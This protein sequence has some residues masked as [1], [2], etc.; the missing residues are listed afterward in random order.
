MKEE[1]GR[2]EEVKRGITRDNDRKEEKR[3]LSRWNKRVRERA[4]RMK[5]REIKNVGSRER[6]R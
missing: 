5:N 6:K 3:E 1:S 4:T 2:K